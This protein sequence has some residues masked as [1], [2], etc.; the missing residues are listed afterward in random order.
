MKINGMKL[1][2]LA[3]EAAKNAYAPYSCY[4][5][6]AVILA[7]DGKMFCGCNVENVAFSASICAE[8]AAVA[9]A[10]SAGYTEFVAI[11]IAGSGM[12]MAYPCRICRQV[13]AEFLRKDTKI[14]CANSVGKY[15]VFTLEELLPY[16][17]YTGLK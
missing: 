9:Q 15:E 12:E 2:Q 13:L 3:R 8:R 16:R 14:F 17:F 5:V 7:P 1:V 10:V 4:R 11:A 6:G